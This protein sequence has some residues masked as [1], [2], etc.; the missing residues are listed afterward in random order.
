[1][2][3]S[4]IEY[5]EKYADDDHEYRYVEVQEECCIAPNQ[6]CNTSI[7]SQWHQIMELPC[8]RLPVVIMCLCFHNVYTIHHSQL[9]LHSLQLYL[10]MSFF[11]KNCWDSFQEIVSS[12]RV[13]GAGLVFSNQEDGSITHCTGKNGN[14]NLTKHIQRPDNRWA[15]H[16]MK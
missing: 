16:G 8:F 4:R 7:R 12:A 6:W 3:A 15:L 9:T 13:N 14:T 5:S 1:M 2:S 10:D 11:Q